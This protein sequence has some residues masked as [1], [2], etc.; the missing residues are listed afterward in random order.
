MTSCAFAPC[1]VSDTCGLVVGCTQRRFGRSVPAQ[2]A[3]RPASKALVGTKPR[4]VRD[5]ATTRRRR[6]AL[7]R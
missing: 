4:P 6:K 5:P 7:T 3:P 2:D 1:D